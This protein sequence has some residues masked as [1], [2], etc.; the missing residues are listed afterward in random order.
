MLVSA[1]RRKE[2]LQFPQPAGRRS[3]TTGGQGHRAC[4][5]I[6]SPGML[7]Y[8]RRFRKTSLLQFHRYRKLCGRRPDGGDPPRR[9]R[10]D[11]PSECRAFGRTA[12]FRRNELPTD[13]RSLRTSHQSE[14]KPSGRIARHLPRNTENFRLQ[15][16]IH[17]LSMVEFHSGRSREQSDACQG[18]SHRT[19]S[20]GNRKDHHLGRGHLRN[21][22]S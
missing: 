9:F 3:G 14:R 15:F 6:R 13:V 22:S 18:C 16:W 4:I 8:A 21:P 5:R 19:R 7:L 12:L 20:S 1:I 17:A 11:G 2:L 10:I